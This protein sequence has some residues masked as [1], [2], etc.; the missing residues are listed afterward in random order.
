MATFEK[1]TSVEITHIPASLIDSA[2]IR[3]MGISE[4]GRF[5]L[6]VLSNLSKD[7]I[8]KKMSEAHTLYDRLIGTE[9]QVAE[10]NYP[11][12]D[13][14]TNIKR[15]VVSLSLPEWARGD[16]RKVTEKK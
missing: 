15:I 11:R 9:V 14:T 7:R 2:H 13:G 10:R 6:R 1:I 8:A 5:T 16:W 12:V 4:N 3:I